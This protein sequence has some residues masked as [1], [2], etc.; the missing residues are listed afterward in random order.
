MVCLWGHTWGI[1]CERE[2]D[3]QQHHPPG[4]PADADQEAAAGVR[5]YHRKDHHVFPRVKADRRANGWCVFGD[6]A[7]EGEAHAQRSELPGLD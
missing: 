4:A 1:T 6:A 5:R 3:A 7:C 2:A